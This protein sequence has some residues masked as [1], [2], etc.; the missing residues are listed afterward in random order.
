MDHAGA[1]A[2]DAPNYET[3]TAP[4]HRLGQPARHQGVGET[5]T[6]AATPAVCRCRGRR[7]I[8]LGVDHIEA[9]P[10]HRACL[11]DDPGG[12]V[13]EPGEPART[14]RLRLPHAGHASAGPRSARTPQGRRRSSGGWSEPLPA[15]KLRLA[16]PKH[17]VDL[18]RCQACRASRKRADAGRRRHDDVPPSSAL[19]AEVEV[20]AAGAGR[21]AGRRSDGAQPRHPRWEPRPRGS[22]G[23]GL[24]GGHHRARGGDG[25]GG[26]RRAS[27]RSRRTTSSRACSPPRS[28]RTRSSP[29]SACPA[30]CRKTGAC[31]T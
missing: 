14:S 9:M 10:S 4:R 31:R 11:E 6:I 7:A 15:M 16:Q 29:R 3:S 5:G 8:G 26:G 28:P 27:G 2:T 20:P 17:L 19:V 18:R 24:P 30:T 1:E 12:Q 22:A 13:A 25:G 23:G 21:R